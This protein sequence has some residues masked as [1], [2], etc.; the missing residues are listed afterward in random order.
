MDTYIELIPYYATRTAI[1]VLSLFHEIF[2][3]VDYSRS[4]DQLEFKV[5]LYMEKNSVLNGNGALLFKELGSERNIYLEN[6]KEHPYDSWLY[7]NDLTKQ[8]DDISKV[9]PDFKYSIQDLQNFNQICLAEIT[10]ITASTPISPLSRQLDLYKI[11]GQLREAF[12]DIYNGEDKANIPQG[13]ELEYLIEKENN[14]LLMISI[15]S[16]SKIPN[17]K[18]RDEYFQKVYD[19][20]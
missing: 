19:S 9:K 5:D 2:D 15:E 4:H 13:K 11:T 10:S 1:V 12:E 8:F 7:I 14:P 16:I 3:L 6:P 17:K 18:V 20:L